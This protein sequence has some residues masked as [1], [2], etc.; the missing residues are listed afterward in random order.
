MKYEVVEKLMQI[1]GVKPS[2]VSRDTGIPS[3]VF[4]DWKKGRYTPKA[5]KIFTLAQYFGVPMEIFFEDKDRIEYYY[6]KIQEHINEHLDQ[7]PLYR[8]SAGQ[9]AYN[10]TYADETI[11]GEEGYEY[12][13]VV[14]DSMFPV[15]QDGDV[16]KVK[17][18]TETTAH[19]LTLVKVDGEHATI[20]YVEIVSN[21]VWLRAE[22]K[23][24]FEDRFYTIQEVLTLPVTVI[25]KVV[26][27]SRKIK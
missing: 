1:N 2:D 4:T 12:A 7:K 24:V 3:S 8:A 19:D 27:F 22:N 18:Q 23:E 14:G 6:S 5:D 13:T 15:L 20:K 9:G 21:G 26:E 11:S 17:P 16:V 10:D 25:G